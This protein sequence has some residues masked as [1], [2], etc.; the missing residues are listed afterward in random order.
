[1]PPELEL[2]AAATSAGGEERAEIL[3]K[4]K[5]RRRGEVDCWAECRELRDRVG[6]LWDDGRDFVGVSRA[7]SV[8]SVDGG[9][10]G[11]RY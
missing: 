9:G 3:S 2:D 5:E 4:D 8:T 11:V 7:K 1:M 6:R 10:W